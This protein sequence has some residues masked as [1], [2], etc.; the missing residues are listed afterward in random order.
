[1]PASDRATFL[2]PSAEDRPRLLS[3]LGRARRILGLSRLLTWGTR[4]V[5]L[6]SL[7]WVPGLVLLPDPSPPLA[8]GFAGVLAGC[9]AALLRWP[10]LPDAARVLDRCYDLQERSQTALERV[11]EQGPMIRLLLADTAARLP[12]ALCRRSL[13]GSLPWRSWLATGVLLLSGL[14]LRAWLGPSGTATGPHGRGNEAAMTPAGRAAKRVGLPRG[15]AGMRGAKAAAPGSRA[16]SGGQGRDPRADSG[17]GP[18]STQEDL[19]GPDAGAGDAATSARGAGPG[20][21]R[22]PKSAHAGSTPGRASSPG[23]SGQR[24][25]GKGAGSDP[26]PRRSPTTPG[27][28]TQAGKARTLLIHGAG[29][30]PV[31]TGQQ[32]WGKTPTSGLLVAPGAGIGRGPRSLP[33]R[34]APVV[35]RYLRLGPG[36][37]RAAPESRET[38]GAASTGP[39]EAGGP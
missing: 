4:A 3:V 26:L 14:G 18:S 35:E 34:Y 32:P 28:G 8:L 15:R 22:G 27:P 16:G 12:R 24:A 25:P 23:G 7:L 9:L 5:L 30:E 11:E 21:G 33:L 20:S 37:P 39:T 10:R 31:S 19:L 13:A 2:E 29:E 38:G 6:S 1:M 17:R 36:G